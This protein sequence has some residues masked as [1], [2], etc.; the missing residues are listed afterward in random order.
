MEN[1]TDLIDVFILLIIYIIFSFIVSVI[2]NYIN[3]TCGSEL[4]KTLLIL[5]VTF[6]VG[7][8]TINFKDYK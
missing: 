7:Y 5:G 6:T 1:K 2:L 4:F 3:Y 8:L